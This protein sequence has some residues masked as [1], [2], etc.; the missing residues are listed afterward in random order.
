MG[1]STVARCSRGSIWSGVSSVLM[2]AKIT[3]GQS[4]ADICVAVTVIIAFSLAPDDWF[5]CYNI[6][7]KQPVISAGLAPSV[8]SRSLFF[9]VTIQD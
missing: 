3:N 9:R 6:P 7:N 1:S 5:R 8:P 4:S 2:C